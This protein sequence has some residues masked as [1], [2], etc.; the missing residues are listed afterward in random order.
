MSKHFTLLNINHMH[1]KYL[2]RILSTLALIVLISNSSFATSTTV[3]NG[4]NSGA[5]SLRAALID[6]TTADTVFFD[7]AVA[8]IT[9]SSQITIPRDV[10]IIGNGINETILSGGN[11]TRLL[12]SNFKIYISSMTNSDGS[13]TGQ[14]GALFNG[15]KMTIE[16]V[17][18]LI[19]KRQKKVVLSLQQEWIR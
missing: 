4:N 18:L 11:N 13:N 14:G 19:M 8:T 6:S 12:A 5:E 9:L 7:P 1:Y 10:V 15:G 16:N 17:L 2:Q 3:T